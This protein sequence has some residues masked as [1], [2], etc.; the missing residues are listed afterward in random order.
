MDPGAQT[1]S[2]PSKLSIVFFFFVA[3]MEKE[4]YN[5]AVSQWFFH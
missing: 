1:S 2:T 4:E 5:R 3:S